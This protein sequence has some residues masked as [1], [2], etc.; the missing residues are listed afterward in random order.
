MAVA[1]VRGDSGGGG[2][3]GGMSVKEYKVSV[4]QDE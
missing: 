2:N 1:R 3:G 4:M